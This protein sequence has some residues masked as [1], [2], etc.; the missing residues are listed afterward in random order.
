[1]QQ[2]RYR[3]FFYFFL[4]IFLAFNIGCNSHDFGHSIGTERISFNQRWTFHYGRLDSAQVFTGGK[5]PLN[6]LMD[7]T[8]WRAVMLPH[9]W[10]IFG[11]FTAEN[12]RKNGGSALPMG[13][14]WYRKTFDLPS[15]DKYKHISIEFDGVYRNSTVWINGHKLGDQH[16]GHIGFAYDLSKYLHF[17][18][19]PNVLVVRVD[20]TQQP[21]A[22]WYTG[23]GINRDVWLVKKMPI[24]VDDNESYFYTT[25]KMP[26]RNS[27]MPSKRMKGVVAELSQELVIDNMGMPAV[28]A[29]TDNYEKK[30]LEAQQH[31]LT[32]PIQIKT[33][34]FDENNFQVAQ[35]NGSV[36]PKPGRQHINWKLQIKDFNPW[37]P[38][39][40]YLY[41][42]E[43]ELRQ[44]S[45]L[46]DRIRKP[47]GIRDIRFDSAKGFQLNGVY[48]KI[49]GVC[50][51]S[52]WGALGTAY[53]YSAMTRQLKIL[54]DMGCN[55]IRTIHHAPAP[56]MLSLCDSLGFLVM[57][58]A[59]D[60][61]RVLAREQRSDTNASKR[62]EQILSRFIKRDRFHP[63]V[64]LWSLGNTGHLESDTNSVH[65]AEN[66]IRVIRSLDSTRPVTAAMTLLDPKENKL[67]ASGVLD[68]LGINYHNENYDSLPHYYPGSAFLA[69]ETTD[70]LE[71]REAYA[72]K[73][74][75][76]T[77]FLPENLQQHYADTTGTHWTISA[78]DRY[79][80]PWG[81]THEAALQSI[82]NKPFIS[83]SF[84][85]TGFD[86]M[87]GSLPF[88]FPARSAYSGIIDLAG[89]HKD[90]YFM[91]QS[92]WA[93]KAIL[94]IFPHW[95]WKP[96][97]TVNVWAYYSQADEVELLLNGK[98]M[99]KRSKGDSKPGDTR[100][101]VSWRVPFKAGKLEAIA[102]KDGVT[103][104]TQEVKT[105]GP[106]ARLMASVDQAY[107]R[108]IIGDLIFVTVRLTDENGVLVPNDDQNIEFSVKGPA[109]LVGLSN[110]YQAGLLSPKGNV[111]RTW[112]GKV[113]AI[114][115]PKVNK[116]H[117]ELDMKAE[118]LE[119]VREGILVGE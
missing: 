24:T 67:A 101:H 1:M 17:N 99:G 2:F 106:A 52:D 103:I 20:N 12:S 60:D 115:E 30:E 74:P 42:W 59:F 5:L 37:S 85:W 83:G 113:V 27:T 78:Y 51:N 15:T 77:Q 119:P 70:A 107:F 36:K 116:G 4:G 53:N 118:G 41:T 46:I 45:H 86:Y 64:I 22:D 18:E 112:K 16:N 40:P 114:I 38:D 7:T 104:L 6:G 79:A 102:R 76:S 94:H 71:T 8:H 97:D 13:M 56:Q 19:R 9:D 44:G 10:S 66:M 108:G 87:G 57:D 100:L 109:S 117:I 98:S 49:K 48:T 89:L 93:D 31:R 95:N 34:I 65:M 96:G 43:I 29:I 73:I 63:S 62:N 82:Q 88:P 54:K 110:G 69:T 90:V 39:D 61:W 91:Y 35:K 75:D 32:L 14:G 80:T 3:L 21:A 11:K 58:E 55:A 47:L 50:M 84:V 33:T 92:E 105:A 68:V 26:A 28:Q 111:F 23:S 25:V 81:M 72:T